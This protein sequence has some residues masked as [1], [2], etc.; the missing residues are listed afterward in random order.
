MKQNYLFL[1][2]VLIAIAPGCEAQPT[3][4]KPVF[5]HADTLRGSIT[6]GRS[7]WDLLHYTIELTPDYQRKFIAGSNQIRFKILKS[8]NLMQIDLQEP[9]IIQDIQWRGKKLSWTRDGNV[10]FVRFPENLKE[11]NI[12][13][14]K[15]MFEGNPVIAKRPPWQGGWIFTQDKLGRPWMTVTCQGLGASIWY[16]CKDHQSDEPD[17]GASLTM[18]VPDTLVAIANGRLQ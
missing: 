15:I 3:E 7:W 1:A 6:P 9:M 8:A 12:E 16:P 2:F 4:P 10:F 13:T 14:I 5:T 17:N 11:G 18:I